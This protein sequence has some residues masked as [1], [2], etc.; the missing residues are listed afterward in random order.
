[1]TEEGNLQGMIESILFVAGEAVET[2][3]LAKALQ[4][5]E[6]ELESELNRLSDEYDYRQRGFM[7][8]RFGSKVQLGT[9]PMYADAVVRLLQP[10]Q[11]QSLSQAAMESM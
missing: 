8:K 4:I 2:K 6:D 9:R 5:S 7:I 3:D 1:M 11:K 10:I